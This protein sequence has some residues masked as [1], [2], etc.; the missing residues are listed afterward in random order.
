[1]GK[2]QKLISHSSGHW[3]YE[4]QVPA[5]DVSRKA[6]FMGISSHGLPGSMQ[7]E[8]FPLSPLVSIRVY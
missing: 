5:A 4:I 1:V 2:K 3:K 6:F 7:A 8:R